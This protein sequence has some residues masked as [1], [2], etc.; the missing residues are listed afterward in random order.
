MQLGMSYK[1]LY[2]YVYNLDSVFPAKI[3]ISVNKCFAST[4]KFRHAAE[5][6]QATEEPVSYYLTTRHDGIR[7]SAGFSGKWQRLPLAPIVRWQRIGR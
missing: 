3:S 5:H 2:R 1:H 7:K 4:I 6:L